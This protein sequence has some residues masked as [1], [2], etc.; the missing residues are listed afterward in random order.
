ME[1]THARLRAALISVFASIAIFALKI[2]AYRQTHSAAVLSDA[3]EGIV[4]VVASIVALF[5]VR[6]AAQPADQ[7][8]PYGHGKAEYFSSAF[9][10]GMI[11]FAALVIGYEAVRALLV[12]GELHTLEVGLAIIG[13]AAFLNLA[14]GLYLRRTGI[15]HKSEALKASGVHV[16]SDVW[17]TVGIMLGLGLV[18]L[19]G[20]RWLDPLMAALV[21]L[22]LG[23]SG[24]KIVHESISSLIDKTDEEALGELAAALNKNR[25]TGIIDLH[26]LRMIRSG[27]FHHVDA[28][29]V[30]PEYWD[31]S[32][33]HNLTHEFEE[34]VVHDYPAD[35]EIAFHV[36]PCKQ[37]YCVYCDVLDCPIR[38]SEFKQR[39][40]FTVAHLTAGPEPDY[41]TKAASFD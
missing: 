14:L 1:S 20:L 16:L 6:F 9:E 38:L 15:K 4:N 29:V 10:G 28:H 19:T 34:R 37:L 2:W 24:F 35:G 31:V 21:A 41:G 26:H 39:K 12:G 8:H 25:A 18:L 11:F 7:D 32:K 27:S 17:T 22:Q 5:V 30:V 3:L 33:A 36:D 13:V 23:Y 40:E